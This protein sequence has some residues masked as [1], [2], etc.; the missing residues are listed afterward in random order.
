[1]YEQDISEEEQIA[2]AVS[3][4]TRKKRNNL[5]LKLLDTIKNDI[6]SFRPSQSLAMLTMEGLRKG[7]RMSLHNLQSTSA[8]TPKKE[9]RAEIDI[10]VSGGGLKAYYMNGC[11]HILQH[12]LKKQ[13]IHIARIGGA[14]GGAWA[15]LFMLTNIGVI[16]WLDTYYFC[17]EKPNLT[18]HEVYTEI[19]P[20]IN[21]QLPE[22]SWEICSGRLF[23]SITEFTGYGFKN[24]IISEFTSNFDLFECC[25]A[26]SAIPYVTLPTMFRVYRGMWVLDGGITNNTPIFTDYKRRQLVFRLG[27]V[28]YPV[29]SVLKAQGE[30]VLCVV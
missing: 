10:V 17:Q 25:M 28:L 7:S 15:G 11:N 16:N 22:N 19:W 20:L 3:S 27:D 9:P 14:S 29:K 12:E 5:C 21:A 26:S 23:I 8:A 18:I 1:M 6:S 2:N 30:N 13:N 4:F 24:H